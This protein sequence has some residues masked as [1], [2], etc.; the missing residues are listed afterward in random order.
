MP[1]GQ[2]NPKPKAS[3]PTSRPVRDSH[4][5]ASEGG[6]QAKFY[7]FRSGKDYAVGKRVENS[8]NV[9]ADEEFKREHRANYKKG[10][11]IPS[12]KVEAAV[13]RYK[14]ARPKKGGSW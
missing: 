10:A 9:A 6:K 8:Y 1:K 11:A 2:P 4:K 12:Y 14:G 3:G 5:S 7:D 13:D